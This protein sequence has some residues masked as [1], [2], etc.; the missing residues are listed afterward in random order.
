[1]HRRALIA[2][3]TALVA[4]TAG[5]LGSEDKKQSEKVIKTIEEEV[6]VDDWTLEEKT[7]S[8]RYQTTGS[9]STDLEL[10]GEAYAT[11]AKKRL[12]RGDLD[13]DLEAT[14]LGASNTFSFTIPKEL[15]RSRASG[16][17]SQEEYV[18]QIA[19]F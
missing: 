12:I 6:T 15:A 3:T 19:D 17:L 1:M 9:I 18:E 2:S 7:L 14:A 4:S 13:V 10:I 16:K 5:C 11:A 8:I